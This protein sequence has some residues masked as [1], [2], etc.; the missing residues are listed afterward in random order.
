MI[1]EATGNSYL[2]RRGAYAYW[3]HKAASPNGKLR[4]LLVDDAAAQ[5][6]DVATGLNL[7]EGLVADDE[8]AYFK[9]ADALYRV[10]LSGGT[11]EQ[12]SPPVAAHDAQATAIY[13]VDEQ[14]V[15]FAAGAGS[16]F[17]TLVR[18]AK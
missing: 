7:P 3:T 14:Y 6:E 18:V 15:Y 1:A 8:Y 16:G 17:S 13:H 4:R 12:L 9:Q 11:P 5:P 10:P 2:V